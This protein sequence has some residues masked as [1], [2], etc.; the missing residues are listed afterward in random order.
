MPDVAIAT[1]Q[2][3]AAAAER[4]VAHHAE[5]TGK[6]T[7]LVTA[8]TQASSAQ[9][10]RAARD[11]LVTWARSELMPHAE[12]EERSLYRAGG[13]VAELKVLIPAMV[14]EHRVI[15]ELIGT[16]SK[17]DSPGAI[18]AAA[19]GLREVVR[20]HVDKENEALLPALVASGAHSVAKLFDEMHEA[21]ADSPAEPGKHVCSCGQQDDGAEPEL[22]ARS[23]PHAIRHAT[24]FGALDTVEPGGA[25][26]LLAPHDPV[27]LLAQLERRSPGAFAVEYL[28]RGPEVWRLR[29][30]RR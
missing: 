24:I 19:G 26:V 30:V 22:D 29:F 5:L 23:I 1:N 18:A 4:I 11:R 2:E 28:E 3:D 13:A 8:A 14:A 6:L 17:A 27:P 15:D 10:A 21:L 25:L 9:E 16:L 12:A 20:V 7:V